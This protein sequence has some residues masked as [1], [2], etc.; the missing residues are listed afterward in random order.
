MSAT[1]SDFLQLPSGGCL[2]LL[3]AFA[4]LGANLRKTG[5][6]VRFVQHEPDFGRRGSTEGAGAALIVSRFGG[7]AV[8][9]L[10]IYGYLQVIVGLC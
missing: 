3:Q 1:H 7:E 5:S 8:R 6:N 4:Q 2:L 10:H 9:A